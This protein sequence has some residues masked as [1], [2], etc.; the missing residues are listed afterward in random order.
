MKLRTLSLKDKA[1]FDK[2]LTLEK[3]ELS[4]Y[5]FANIYIWKSLF[6]IRWVV[7][8]KSLCIFFQDQLGTFLYLP[9][10]SRIKDPRVIDKI[11]LDRAITRI[12][13]I[14]E[15][16]LAFYRAL[17]YEV[18]DKFPEYLCKRK[19]IADLKGNKFKHKRAERNYFLKH[20]NF[21]HLD[22]KPK[23]K[24]GCLELCAQW[25]KKR[26]AL[27]LDPVYQGMLM[28]SQKCLQA[29]LKD[30]RKLDCAG[31]VVKISSKIKGFT[32]GFKL[33]NDT[34]CIL[35]EITDL[36]VKGLAQF[37]FSEF[38]SELKGYPYINIM[39]DSGLE[40]LKRVKLSWRPAR[41]I[42]AYIVNNPHA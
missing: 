35:Y 27:N 21:Q 24:I 13:N 10:L 4:V 32:L 26:K 9:P 38:C 36:S 22:L 19:E 5:S 1:L 17:G 25:A 14:E 2:Y 6:R 16:D 39:D 8:A 31:R 37:I 11:F 12:E 7:I 33:S 23:D 29:L 18:K 15:S 34:F 42:P 20:Y 40:N 30:Y 28:D 41:V 3:H